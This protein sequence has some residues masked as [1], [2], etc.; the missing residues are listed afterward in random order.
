[1]GKFVGQGMKIS[2]GLLVPQKMFDGSPLMETIRKE[3]LGACK[4]GMVVG[5]QEKI[6]YNDRNNNKDF[7]KQH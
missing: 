4:E 6:Q 1:V 5:I 3:D 7:I 2:V